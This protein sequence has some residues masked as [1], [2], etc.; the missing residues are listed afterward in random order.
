MGDMKG[1]NTTTQKVAPDPKAMQ[2]YTDLLNR[3]SGVA[4]QPYQAY[5]GNLTAGVN[6]QQN[7]GI[8]GINNATQAG[9]PWFNYASSMAHPI[10]A[11][12]IERYQNPY[13]QQV[14]NATQAQFDRSNA[15]AQERLQG[16][17]IAQGALG[18]SRAKI[19]AAD[20]AYQQQVGQ[21]PT[22]AG[23]FQSG[24]DRSLAAAQQQQ[25]A[26]FQGAGVGS[27]IQ[28]AGLQGA[29]AQIGAGTLQQQTEQNRLN[30]DY[31]QFQI[32]QA[33]PY[34]QAQWLA[35]IDSSVGPQ[36]GGTAETTAP[37][38][39]LLSQVAGAGVAGAGVAS[40]LGF[41]P[42]AARGGRIE[43]YDAGGSVGAEPYGGVGWIPQTK[44]GGGRGLMPGLQPP[45]APQQHKPSF[46]PSKFGF[47]RSGERQ[48]KPSGVGAADAE[49]GIGGMAGDAA[50]LGGMS[51]AD[52]LAAA[53]DTAP[54]AA[55]VGGW[56]S[57]L[58]GVGSSLM[59]G[60]EGLGSS[61]AG[62]GSSI[63]S[64]LPEGVAAA[65]PFLLLNRGGGVRGYADAGAVLGMPDAGA[66]DEGEQ[67][68]APSGVAPAGEWLPDAVKGVQ[69]ALSGNRGSFPT[70]S[71]S[72]TAA[73]V[74]PVAGVGAPPPMQGDGDYGV[75]L[76]PEPMAG[77]GAPPSA[78]SRSGVGGFDW[79]SLSMPLITAGLGMMASR[80]PHA[81]VGIG[82]GGLQGVQAYAQQQRQT[83]EHQLAEKKQV[84]DARRLDQMAQQARQTL[85]LRT[86]QADIHERQVDETAKYRQ[87]RLGQEAL[88]PTGAMTEDNHPILYDSRRPGV[89]IDGVT[90]QPLKPGQKVI[91]P[92]ND[93]GSSI[94]EEHKD[95]RGEE[96]LATLPAG[97]SGFVKG[98]AEYAIDPKTLSTRGGQRERYLKMAMQYDPNFRQQRYNEIY[99]AV[100]RFSTG[101]QG[102]TVKSFNV[103]IHHLGTLE[104]AATALNN[105]DFPTFNRVKNAIT[106]QLGYEAPNTFE[107]VRDIVANEMVKAIIGSGGGVGDREE[108]HKR[109]SAANSPA[110]LTAV[111]SS[112]KKLM[113]GQMLGLK[114]QYEDATGLQNFDSKLMPE[115]I[116]Q[117]G[118]ASGHGAPVAA[119]AAS[120][121]NK[122]ARDWL[123]ANP[124][125]PRA[126]AIRKKLGIE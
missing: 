19:A 109:I 52:A 78:S 39:S 17:A 31:N 92:K 84:L 63:M 75:D 11:S 93:V 25:Q 114:K 20:M 80:S 40:G 43:D 72:Q 83:Q 13:T 71:S 64:A 26:G 120:D 38:P 62:V 107:A 101:K 99:N 33:F 81:L 28:Q 51:E 5:T 68:P 54:E 119:P 30:A 15:Q 95:L 12:D 94:P 77:V 7:L 42:F 125:D 46:D 24:F 76:P 97:E 102:D 59:G 118:I 87:D 86:R 3:A 32:A 50:P 1:T 14:V 44:I 8:A 21:A 89:A 27:A 90:G 34:Q 2:A 56:F 10:G 60:L 82:E 69:L 36:M 67:W 104:E 74:S 73:P 126:P 47:P 113:A 122:A 85:A 49:E 110:Q 123:A 111:I 29:G 41:K 116:R 106:N 70:L 79:S 112:Y 124:N 57:G 61:L 105:K 115:T 48:Q 91:N 45:A 6:Q 108:A 18:G 16:Q 103:A 88:K 65:L 23:L 4:S 66:P 121:P 37:A 9:A 55:G 96:Y 22:I 100:N 98:L 117:L 35:G 58:E 53:A